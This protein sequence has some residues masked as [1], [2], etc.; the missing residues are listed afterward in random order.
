MTAPAISAAPDPN[1]RLMVRYRM[2]TAATPSSACGTRM[3]HALTPKTRANASIT[4]S[5]AGDLSTVIE[6]PASSEPKKKAFQLFVEACTAI[7]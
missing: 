4:Q 7:E 1:H 6:L 5:D 3:L 2:P